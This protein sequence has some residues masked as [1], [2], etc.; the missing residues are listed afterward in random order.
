MQVCFCFFF[1]I[2]YILQEAESG[3]ISQKSDEEDFVKV[4]DL[5]LKLTIYSEVFGSLIKLSLYNKYCCDENM[6][7]IFNFHSQGRSKEENGRRRT[8]KPF[9]W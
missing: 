1:F 5:P 2:K 6:I 3:N 8:E 7:Y 9:I 4:E